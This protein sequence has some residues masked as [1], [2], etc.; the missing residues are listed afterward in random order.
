MKNLKLF[1]SIGVILTL[2]LRSE[3]QQ[4]PIYSMN[5]VNKY[6]VNPAVV[7]GN[8][9]TDIKMIAREQYT[10]F[11]NAP[12]TFAF[13]G[14]SRI[15]DDSYI[16]RKLRVRK[17][18]DNA[19]RFTNVGLGG[20]IYSDRNGIVGR[21]GIQGSYAYHINFNNR[22][23]FSMGLSV[24]FSQFK[25]DDSDAIL[26][27]TD[28]PLLLG[29]KKVFWIPDASFGA[30]ITNNQLF[31]GITITDV[32]GSNLKL[33]SDP[34]KE[35]FY[36]MRNYILLGGYKM[37]LSESFKFEPSFLLRA[38][39]FSRQL[40]LNTKV[41]YMDNYWAGLSYRTN[42][43]LVT[44]IGLNYGILEFAYAYDA[45]VGGIKTYSGG[46][47]E[48]IIGFRFGDKSTKRYRWIQKD[49]TEF[50]M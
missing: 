7:G 22:F 17:N 18:T 48:V 41:I 23:Q 50:D 47:H 26:V 12:R 42:Q 29:E 30:F 34:I 10:G 20:S 36:T 25:L 15:L 5:M 9:I 45:S 11:Q 6:L 32:L 31:A 28:D 14:Q 35:N 16:M 2:F 19:S 44:M 21:T 33:G 4:L 49:E 46:S 43:S 27:D 40:D 24:S 39:T 38:T 8:G 3:A 37:N 13:T 1:I